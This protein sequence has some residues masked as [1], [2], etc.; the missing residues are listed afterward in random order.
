MGPPRNVQGTQISD[1]YT[2]GAK[3]GRGATGEVFEAINVV[4][5]EVYAAKR[6]SLRNLTKD[7]L[8]SL[9]SESRRVKCIATVWSL[10]SRSFES[11]SNALR[12][13]MASFGVANS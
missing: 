8:Y 13:K 10:R 3:I 11:C 7:Q 4:T 12:K 1:K 9:E 2:L 5:G 6:I